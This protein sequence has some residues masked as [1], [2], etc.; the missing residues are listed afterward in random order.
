MCDF[1]SLD[2]TLE[3]ECKKKKKSS[4]PVPTSS[5][6]KTLETAVLA[7]DRAKLG[8]KNPKKPNPPL[9]CAPPYL[10]RKL[11]AHLGSSGFP[12]TP[13]VSGVFIKPD[14]SIDDK[15]VFASQKGRQV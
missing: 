1:I 7:D 4:S 2:S 8:K 3:D 9:F 10:N 13:T 12:S 15:D 11:P 14:T 6:T 5:V